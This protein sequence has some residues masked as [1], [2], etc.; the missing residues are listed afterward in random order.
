VFISDFISLKLVTLLLF[1]GVDIVDFL[2]TLRGTPWKTDFK[3]L[4]RRAILSQSSEHLD[5]R[6]QPKE[7]HAAI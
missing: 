5:V 7:D 4:S 6:F 3:G 1:F 2:E